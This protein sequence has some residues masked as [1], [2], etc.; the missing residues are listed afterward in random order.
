[1]PVG[2]VIVG[3]ARFVGRLLRL[4]DEDRHP[5]DAN[6]RAEQIVQSRTDL[7]D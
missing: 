4:V 1:M 2:R 6:L 3:T 5:D 7:K